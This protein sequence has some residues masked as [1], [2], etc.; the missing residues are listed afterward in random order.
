MAK[1]FNNIIIKILL[2]GVISICLLIPS[3][4]INELNS[5]RSVFSKEA[6]KEVSDK[7]S[8]EQT[9]SGPIIYIPYTY[10]LQTTDSTGKVVKSSKIKDFITLLPQSLEVK[11]N[12]T[13]ESRIRGLYEVVVY[14]SNIEIS[15]KF[16]KNII[17]E[18]DL[19][20]AEIL[21]DK[22]EFL[23]G[24]SD[25]RGIEQQLSLTFGNENFDFNPGLPNK[26]ILS[27]GLTTKINLT[28]QK[29]TEVNFNLNIKLKGSQKFYFTPVGK[30][31][32]VTIESNWPNPSFNGSFLPDSRKVTDKGFSANW[33]ILHLNRNYPQIW[34]GNS[35]NLEGTKFGIDLIIPVD[36]Y[37]KSYRSTKY[38]I[39]F[40]GLTFLVFFFIEIKQKINIH[41]VQYILVGLALVIFYTLLLSITEH[42]NFNFAFIISAIMTII[43]IATYV[44]AILKSNNFAILISLVLVLLYTFIFSIIQMEDYALLIGSIGIFI[45]LATTMYF[46]RKIDWYNLSIQNEQTK[47]DNIETEDSI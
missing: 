26:Q 24:I 34:K 4:L 28:N 42:L 6:I 30:T 21:F 3:G 46:S 15:G 45:I 14:N 11:G 35:F 2:I 8:S 17:S 43:L 32:D 10:N 23:V 27:S 40:I 9:I 38:A 22:A 29:E 31:T 19:N 12:L 7:W 16:D 5:E 25:L 47:A 1:L 13:P 36:N 39:L 20:D 37:Q 18:I 44:K 41:P 33:N